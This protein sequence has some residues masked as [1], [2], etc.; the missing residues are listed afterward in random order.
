MKNVRNVLVRYSNFLLIRRIILI[1]LVL[2]SFN[3]NAKALRIISLSPMVTKGIFLL[4]AQKYLVGCSR[5]VV[6]PSGFKVKLFGSVLNIDV[7]NIIRLKP[8]YVFV[9]SMM[10]PITVDKMRNFGIDVV[11][12]D[13]PKSFKEICNQ[14]IKLGSYLGKKTEALRIVKKAKT[15]VMHIYNATKGLAKVRVFV[16]IGV[17]PL[18]TVT[19]NSFINDFIKFA[20]GINIAADSKS[21]LYSVEEV[22][23]KDPEAIIIGQMGFN[24]HLEKKRWERFK[25]LDA[26]KNQKI[27]VLNENSLCSPTP[28][29]FVETLKEITHFLHPN[30]KVN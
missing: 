15:E 29:S 4:G 24:G 16:E 20:G 28:I 27:L 22:L 14:F 11:V 8:D 5:Y 21:G 1:T 2:F 26:V 6:L 30:A 10:N 18:F 17:R 13:Y 3:S 9:S 7:E 25:F 12:F 23:R 19:K